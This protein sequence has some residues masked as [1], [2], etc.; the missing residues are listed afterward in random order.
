MIEMD[1]WASDD[2]GTWNRRF[3]DR[4]FHS[5]EEDVTREDLSRLLSVGLRHF[6][7]ADIRQVPG[8]PGYVRTTT[9]YDGIASTSSL[10][11]GAWKRGLSFW[12]VF[13]SFD[14]MFDCVEMYL[15]PRR[16]V[17]PRASGCSL[18][19]FGTV[20]PPCHIEAISA[21]VPILGSGSR[22]AYTPKPSN[23]E[24]S[25]AKPE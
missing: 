11:R 16:P 22:N 14:E 12:A 2:P 6:Y 23:T 3:R 7:R 5:R 20:D 24:T 15:G 21:R 19:L 8:V 13:E 10:T 18:T 17:W 9:L 4:V 1:G 25:S